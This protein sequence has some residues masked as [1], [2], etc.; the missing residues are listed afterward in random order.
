MINSSTS[1]RIIECWCPHN[2]LPPDLTKANYY[3][4]DPKA[5]I[6]FYEDNNEKLD[7]IPVQQSSLIIDQDNAVAYSYIID[8]NPGELKGQTGHWKQLG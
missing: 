2:K 7:Y 5:G 8:S 3:V 1:D 6:T 4:G